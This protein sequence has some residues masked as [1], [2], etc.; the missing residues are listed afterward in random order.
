MN[1]RSVKNICLTITSLA[2]GGAEKQCLLLASL[3][4]KNYNVL[5][6]IMEEQPVHHSHV[7]FIK[8]EGIRHIFLKGNSVS[9]VWQ[10]RSIFRQEQIDLIFS[11]LPKDIMLSTLASRAIVKHHIGG[12]RNALMERS[13]IHF[14]KW[15]HNHFLDASISNCVSGRDF[16]IQQGLRDKK[17]FVIPNG[18]KIDTKPIR[19]PPSQNIVISSFGRL[20]DQKDFSTAIRS[21]VYLKTLLDPS[22]YRLRLQIVGQGPLQNALQKEINT[23]GQEEDIIILSEAKDLP[24]ILKLTDIYLCTSIFEG[25]SNAIMEAMS[26]SLPIVATDAGDNRLLVNHLTNGYIVPVG[27]YIGIGNALKTLVEAY[28][29]RIAFGHESYEL[30]KRNHDLK[31][32]KEHY[33]SFIQ[34]VS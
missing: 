34:K 4:Q 5:V 29:Q 26:Y 11:Y 10:L 14:I 27:D 28:E 22:I 8:S 31:V 17:I 9:K 21:F 25:V 30:L 19:R 32:F 3:L 20:V 23:L 12:I 33:I 1:D 7:N 2:A 15:I 13:K 16:F 24:S 6:V 18:I